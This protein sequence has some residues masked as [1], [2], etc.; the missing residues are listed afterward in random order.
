MQHSVNHSV[1]IHLLAQ[2]NNNG[3]ANNISQTVN[4]GMDEMLH[5]LRKTNKAQSELA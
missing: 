4:R 3:Q 2:Y 5:V 1:M